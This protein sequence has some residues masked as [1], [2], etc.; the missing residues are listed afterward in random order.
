MC[1]RLNFK[2]DIAENK[3]SIK[4]SLIAPKSGS[5]DFVAKAAVY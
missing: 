5:K 1:P 3:Q 2:I 4:F